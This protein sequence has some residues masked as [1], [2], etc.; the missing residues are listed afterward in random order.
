MSDKKIESLIQLIVDSLRFGLFLHQVIHDV[1]NPQVQ[2]LH[3]FLTIFRPKKRSFQ[4][5]FKRI[6][7]LPK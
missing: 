6:K 4:E 5:Y 1:I 3:R 2:F 7:K